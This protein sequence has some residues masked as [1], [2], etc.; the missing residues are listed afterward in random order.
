[1]K[2][3]VTTNAFLIV[4]VLSSIPSGFS[5]ALFA[6]W[7][8]ET[9]IQNLISNDPL[10]SFNNYSGFSYSVAARYSLGANQTKVIEGGTAKDASIRFQLAKGRLTNHLDNFWDSR[11]AGLHFSYHLLSFRKNIHISSGLYGEIQWNESTFFL[12][13]SEYRGRKSGFAQLTLP[14]KISYSIPNMSNHLIIGSVQTNLVSYQLRPGYSVFDPDKLLNK[15]P[16]F[17]NILKTG[18]FSSPTQNVNWKWMLQWKPN[19]RHGS[20][21]YIRME[22]SYL[23]IDFPKKMSSVHTSLHVGVHL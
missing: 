6:Q 5:Q 16:T 21:Y 11:F 8:Y 12:N 17:I 15:T 13:N 2:S 20:P 3:F 7:S 23:T 22:H 9:G 1:M 4:I 14:F 18:E 19:Y 10:L